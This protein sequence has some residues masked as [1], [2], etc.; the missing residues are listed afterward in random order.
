MIRSKIVVAG[1]L[2]S[3]V[4]AV[5]VAAEPALAGTCMP[6]SVK[7]RGPDPATA[8]TKAAVKLTERAAQLRGKVKNSSTSCQK[9]PPGGF[10][11]TTS[12]VVCP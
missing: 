4:A 2:L 12:A 1:I 7:G 3:A 11:C 8:T 5:A 10:V 9:G 6:V